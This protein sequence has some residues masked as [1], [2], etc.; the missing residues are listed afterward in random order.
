MEPEKAREIY[1][2]SVH[3]DGL[4]PIFWYQP[5]FEVF[6]NKVVESGI[7]AFNH[8]MVTPYDHRPASLEDLMQEIALWEKRSE[9]FSDRMT[10]ARTVHDILD[11]KRTGRVAVIFGLQNAALIGSNPDLLRILHRVGVRII[12][13]TYQYSNLVAGGNAEP[14]DGGLTSL[15]REVVAAMNELGLLICLSH[16]GIESSQEVMEISHDPVVFSHGNVR[17]L[18]DH[19]RNL[20]DAQIDALGTTDGAIGVG[21][22]CSLVSTDPQKVT[23]DQFLN[24][25]DYLVERIG[26]Q[27]VGLGID[28]AEGLP[29]TARPMSTEP[30]LRVL[31]GTYELGKHPSEDRYPPELDSVTKRPALG[32]YLAQ[33]GYREEEIQSILGGSFLRVFRRVW[34]E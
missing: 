5:D 18:S 29:V 25:V 7:T 19:P 33:R 12:G 8:T 23:L 21:A 30:Q 1:D 26:H 6:L 34:K 20:T 28:L 14:T 31:I 27:R 17:K 16:V 11:A 9:I 4:G 2:T 15:G 13:L 3:I 10:I 22:W 24:H 32:G